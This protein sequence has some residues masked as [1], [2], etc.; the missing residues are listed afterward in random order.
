MHRPPAEHLNEVR[1]VQTTN[2]EA[3]QMPRT[4]PE[5][6]PSAAFQLK[7]VDRMVKLPPLT[8]VGVS[9]PSDAFEMRT[10]SC[11]EESPEYGSPS[12]TLGPLC[13]SWRWQKMIEWTQE[14]GFSPSEIEMQ[15][16][17]TA[18]EKKAWF[19]FLVE[20][21]MAS[22]RTDG[23]TIDKWLNESKRKQ[24]LSA[25][26][27]L[28][29]FPDLSALRTRFSKVGLLLIAAMTWSFLAIELGALTSNHKHQA[30]SFRFSAVASRD[31]SQ[32][33]VMHNVAHLQL[34]E[35]ACIVQS[36]HINASVQAITVT[37]TP[38]K[39]ALCGTYMDGFAYQTAGSDPDLDP[40]VFSVEQLDRTNQWSP[41]LNPFSLVRSREWKARPPRR[42]GAH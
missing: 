5:C 23:N 17:L 28:V 20:Q 40:V 9:V 12:S 36:S 30:C 33:P 14:Q 18:D 11:D 34:T 15:A 27:L 38:N 1:V 19:D 2:V 7:A 41:V 37:S 10:N 25:G 4:E 31:S 8:R 6:L 22:M 16:T 24:N 42:R 26:S 35:S 3:S 29:P 13:E 32:P 39:Y 21:Y